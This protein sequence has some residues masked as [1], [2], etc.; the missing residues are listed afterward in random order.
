M[1]QIACVDCS[2]EGKIIEHKCLDCKGNKRR[3]KN[4]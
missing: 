4:V 2:G 1:E 3:V